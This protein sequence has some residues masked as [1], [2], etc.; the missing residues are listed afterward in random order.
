MRRE[1]RM[2]GNGRRLEPRNR[3]WIILLIVSREVSEKNDI[4]VLFVQFI[5]LDFA[6]VFVSLYLQRLDVP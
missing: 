4:I 6:N 1:H 3:C 5:Y 2:Q